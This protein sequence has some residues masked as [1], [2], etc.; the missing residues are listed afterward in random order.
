MKESPNLSLPENVLTVKGLIS[1]IREELESAFTSV[2]VTGEIS[3]LRTPQ[4]GHTYFTLKDSEAQIQ[5]VFFRNKKRYIRFEPEDGLEVLCKGVVTLYEVRGGLQLNVDY[6]E[7]LGVGALHVAF[8]Q[9]KAR[10]ENEGLFDPAH[11]KPLPLLPR[12]IG[13]ITSPT[14]AAIQDILHV[15]D[16]RYGDVEILIAPVRVQGELAAPEIVDAIEK[17]NSRG[18][19]DVLILARGG[20]SIEDLWAFNEE[21]VARAIYASRIPLVSAIGHETDFT[22]ADFVSDFRAP[23]P[24]AA[25]ELV[26]QNKVELE[27]R[28]S[29][30]AKRL[31]NEMGYRVDRYAAELKILAGRLIT[32]EQ[33]ISTLHQRLDELHTAAMNALGSKIRTCREDLERSQTVLRFLNPRLQ[34]RRFRERLQVLEKKLRREIT[35][36]AGRKK[37]RLSSLSSRLDTL[38]PLNVLARGYS[39]VYR[40]PDEQIIRDVRS[41]SAADRLRLRFHHGRADCTVDYVEEG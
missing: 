22:I 12:R 33:R 35:V 15:I 14:G 29:H 4:S 20:G 21:A 34:A 19:L 8:E 26:V 30:L 41:V 11:K 32:P 17:L 9:I 5:A 7:P 38:S 25:A 16:R 13:V 28:I 37:D 1:Q 27:G 2:W 31:V 40:L 23:T 36:I 6:M 24:S 18:N 10:L 3:N 39:I